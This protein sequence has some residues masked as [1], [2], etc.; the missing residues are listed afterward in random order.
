MLQAYHPDIGEEFSRIINDAGYTKVKLA[1][2]A[3]SVLGRSK[4]TMGR[5]VSLFSQGYIYAEHN[6]NGM[7]A[8]LDYWNVFFDKLGISENQD[9]VTMLNNADSRYEYKTLAEIVDN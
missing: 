8:I 2:E 6:P 9:I 3:C 5:A 7:V 1:R 4:N